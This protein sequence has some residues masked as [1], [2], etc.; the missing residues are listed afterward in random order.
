MAKLSP[1]TQTLANHFPDW[2]EVRWNEQSVGQRLFNSFAVPME[3]SYK[4]L[5]RV[6]KNLHLVSTNLD[7]IDWTYRVDL[8]SS[9]EFDSAANDLINTQYTAPVV[10]GVLDGTSYLVEVA[11]NNDIETF[12]YTHLPDRISVGTM[13]SGD[14][15]LVDDLVDNA[16][17]VLE[18]DLP[19]VNSLYVSITG[20]GRYIYI[21]KD[22]NAL[23]RAYVAI[24]GTTDKGTEE[25]ELLAFPWDQKQQTLKEWKTIEK[26]ECLNMPTGAAIL[27][28]AGD[29]ANGPYMDFW[30]ISYSIDRNKIDQ[31]WNVGS[32]DIGATLDVIQYSTDD[33]QLMLNGIFDLSVERSFE[34]LDEASNNISTL[35]DMAQQPFSNNIW[36]VSTDKLYCFDADFSTTANA[37]VLNANTFDRA[38][39]IDTDSVHY[40]RGDTVTLRFVQ[41]NPSINVAKFRPFIIAPDGTKNNIVSGT[42]VSYDENDLIATANYKMEVDLP[43]VFIP[44]QLGEYVVGVDI[45]LIDGVRQQTRKIISVDSKIALTSFNLPND[46]VTSGVLG[47]DF[48]SNQQMWIYTT[49]GCHEINL[50]HDV[51]IVDYDNKVLYLREPYD[52]V[53]IWPSL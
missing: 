32:V 24:T 52:E 31:F 41:K 4:E 30:N 37:E 5:T 40:I 34:A 53:Q 35:L 8:D 44:D 39:A 33:I 43:Y 27:V 9:F 17:F 42:L 14:F 46:L 7:E 47:L 15:T 11:E 51:M 16:P 25:Y 50:H 45:I 23:S 18:Q 19:T 10:S 22:T 36:A 20:G 28:T 1:I 6:S 21:D 29:C 3:H 26:I 13:V 38:I 12:W 49:S 48:D 2:S